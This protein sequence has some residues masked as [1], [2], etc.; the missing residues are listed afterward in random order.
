MTSKREQLSLSR[1]LESSL[2]KGES[3]SRLKTLVGKRGIT[4]DFSTLNAVELKIADIE[5]TNQIRKEFDDDGIDSLA[6]S[7]REHG[8]L[9]PVVVAQKPGGGYLLVAGERRLRAAK[10]LGWFSIPAVVVPYDEGKIR[11]L[12]IVGNLQRKDLNLREKAEGVWEYFCHVWSIEG[13]TDSPNLEKLWLTF[14]YIHGGKR[15]KVKGELEVYL[16]AAE[17]CAKEIGLSA[18]SVLLHCLM[19]HLS[20]KVKERLKNASFVSATHMRLLLLGRKPW[21]ADESELVSLIEKAEQRRLSRREFERLLK[22]ERRKPS[23]SSDPFK[24]VDRFLDKL[25]KELTGD[26]LDRLLKYIVHR[27]QALMAKNEGRGKDAGIWVL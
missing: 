20:D 11:L 10:K 3:V 18:S 25:Q 6:E 5:V 27:A 14:Y 2:V 22:G 9:Q 16:K 17:K 7:S 8:L 15:E 21:E 24:K 12:Q 4:V 1:E 23:V 19:F 26:E 13:G